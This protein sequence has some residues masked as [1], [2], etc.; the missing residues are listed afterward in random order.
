[1]DAG[2]KPSG[3][4]LL[5]LVLA[6]VLGLCACTGPTQFTSPLSDPGSTAY[7]PRLIGDWVGI[8]KNGEAQFVALR[9]RED[10]ELLITYGT[11]FQH[12]LTLTGYAS[13]LGGKTYYNVKPEHSSYLRSFPQAKE[14][15]HYLLFRVEFVNDDELYLWTGILRS[16]DSLPGLKAK[17]IGVAQNADYYLVDAPRGALRSAL[18]TDPR[19]VFNARYGPFFRLGTVPARVRFVS[20]A[21]DEK[22]GCAVGVEGHV[23]PGRATWSGRCR[24]GTASGAGLLEWKVDGKVAG[25]FEGTLVGGLPEGAGRCSAGDSSDWKPCKFE[26]GSPV[27][28]K[29]QLSA[30]VSH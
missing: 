29:P 28:D 9:A 3:H 4:A 15:P 24:D 14:S 13:E 18:Q 5:L 12:G 7:D 6:C 25:R 19:R 21:L 2:R 26:H 27:G 17:R 8:D 22:S 23:F 16:E 20:W 1:V 10:K 30:R 11:I